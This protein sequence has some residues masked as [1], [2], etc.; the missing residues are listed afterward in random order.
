MNLQEYK[1]SV[2]RTLAELESP[3]HDNLHMVLGLVTESGEL[4]DVFKKNIAYGKEIDWVNVKEE[5]G[6]ILF[7]VMGMCTINGWN[8]EDILQT[9][10]DKLNA[11]YGDKFS[12]DAAI[13]R[14]LVKERNTLEGTSEL[15]FDSNNKGVE[16]DWIF[17]DDEDLEDHSY[18][19]FVREGDCGG[20]NNWNPYAD[21]SDTRD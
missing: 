12:T 19:W 21:Y 18:V 15:V 6:D 9:N 20:S 8:L 13:K 4:A 1:E 11:R 7:Y 14:D 17:N 5:L 16:T 10:S 3:W 2:M